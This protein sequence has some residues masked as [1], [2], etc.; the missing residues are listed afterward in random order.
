MIRLRRCAVLSW[1]WLSAHV[2]RHVFAGM[3][4]F[5]QSWIHTSNISNGLEIKSL[6]VFVLYE[7]TYM[8]LTK[9]SLLIS[10]ISYLILYYDDTTSGYD[11]RV[12][13]VDTGLLSRMRAANAQIRLRNAQSDLGLRCPPV[14][15]NEQWNSWSN[16]GFP[17]WSGTSQF[18]YNMRAVFTLP[19]L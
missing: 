5:V 7:E 9:W 10:C 19:L 15:D 12:R 14:Y 16:S 13:R 8:Y 2:S 1:P 4:H 17:S 18:V 6:I 11:E 3:A